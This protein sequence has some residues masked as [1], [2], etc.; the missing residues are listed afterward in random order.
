M[1]L[2]SYRRRGFR[3]FCIEEIRYAYEHGIDPE[4]IEQYM[5]DTA[6]NNISG[7]FRRSAT[8]GAL[9]FIY[10]LADWFF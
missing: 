7:Q 3:P 10:N 1:E 6:F 5:N 9:D 4:L 8:Q 2:S